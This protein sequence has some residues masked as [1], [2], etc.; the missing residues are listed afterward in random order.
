MMMGPGETVLSVFKA[1]G[2]SK[3]GSM[4]YVRIT[5]IDEGKSPKYIA[6]HPR[7]IK[8]GYS[9]EGKLV[10]DIHLGMSVLIGGL[11]DKAHFHTSPVI[12]MRPDG[13]IVTNHSIYKIQEITI[14]G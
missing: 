14:P 9:V 13:I 10:R 8:A 1:F 7:H 12:E 2:A 5:K 11:N 4:P 6:G 3:S